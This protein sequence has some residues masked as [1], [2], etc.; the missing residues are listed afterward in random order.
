M[1][2][3]IRVALVAG[4]LVAL[5]VAGSSGASNGNRK[6]L[7]ATPGQ[8]GRIPASAPRDLRVAAAAWAAYAVRLGA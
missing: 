8:L 2:R 7:D 5:A 6:V 3:S 1:T 4:V